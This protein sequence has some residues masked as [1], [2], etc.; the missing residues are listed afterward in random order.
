MIISWCYVDQMKVWTSTGLSLI[1][2]LNSLF[3]D[4]GIGIIAVLRFLLLT[5]VAGLS[6]SQLEPYPNLYIF[7]FELKLKNSCS[8][9]TRM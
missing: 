6:V 8:L 5:M 1:C 9:S 2:Y 4:S 7:L 3:R